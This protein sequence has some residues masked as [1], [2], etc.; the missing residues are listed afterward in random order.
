MTTTLK[1]AYEKQDDIPE[2]FRPLFSERNGKYE[3][4]GVEGVKPETA[5][6]AVQEAL[7]KEREDHSGAKKQLKA[8]T[9]LGY[10]SVE[11]LQAKLDLIPQL[12]A[13]AAGRVKELTDAQKQALLAPVQRDL[14]KVQ[15]ELATLR[16]ENTALKA[17]KRQRTIHDAVRAAATEAK[18][19]G[20]AVDD[21][22]LLAESHFEVT[23]DGKV[24]VKAD[25]KHFTPGLDAKS[26]LQDM[27]QKRPHWWP[28]SQG[29]GAGGSGAGGGFANNPWSKA[30][31]NLT[32][33]GEIVR[34]Q[35]REK[36][37][38]MAKAAGS[39]IGAVSPPEK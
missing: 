5:F 11:E 24:V 23:E 6:T 20:T 4:T 29:G 16:E 3:L 31:W 34:T 30:H 37:E 9:D 15:E 18:V 36:A 8:F 39:M 35:G 13:A 32:K 12:E 26:W 17:E 22:L 21:V 27:Q 38:Q 2:A 10:S 14:K 7:R 1:S 33:Q 28:P 19:L 25:S